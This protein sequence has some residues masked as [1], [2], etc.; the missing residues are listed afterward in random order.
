M[1]KVSTLS[2]LLFVAL[3]CS[4]AASAQRKALHFSGAV[5]NW[6]A[7]YVGVRVSV[8]GPSTT[9]VLGD[10]LFT[11]SND[12]SGGSTM[13]GA[14]VPPT[15]IDK[16]IQMVAVGGDTCVATTALT[17]GSFTGKI[18]FIYRG[19]SEFGHKAL[20]A[21]NAGAVA[22]VIVNNVAGGAV[23]MAA[24]TE[25]GSVTSIPVVMISKEDGDA[26]DQ[27]Y[28]SGVAVTMTI[29]NWGSNKV[30]D[31][32]F[33]PFGTATWHAYA[34][35]FD[36]LGT[37][38]PDA[39]KA[40]DGAFIANYGSANAAGVSLASSLSFTPNSGSASSLHTSTVVLGAFPVADSVVAMFDSS[41]TATNVYSFS[42]S[43]AGRFDQK[44]T[45]NAATDDYLGN[46]TLTNS[47]YATDSLYSKGRYD[48]ANS[49]PYST[50]Y[51]GRKTAADVIWGNM[52]FVNK[53]G[54]AVR[55]V[56]YS[57]SMNSTTAHTLIDVAST[58][59][60]LYK[61]VDANGDKVLQ[62]GELTM[63]GLAEHQY[64]ILSATT[65]DT[66][67]GVFAAT[68]WKAVGP[69]YGAD[70]VT[71]ESNTWYYLAVQVP[72]GYY[73]GCDGVLDQYPRVYGHFYNK[74]N[75]LLE[76]S[77]LNYTGDSTVISGNPADN[78][79]V[80][81]YT[82]TLFIGSVDSFN[83][84]QG[85][86]LIPSVSMIVN[87]NPTP[88]D[89]SH[90]GVNTVNAVIGATVFPN[91]A[92]NTVTVSLSLDRTAPVVSYTIIDGLARFVAKETTTNV[93]NEMHTIN[94]SN[95]PAGNYDLVIT[96]N[97]NSIV[98]KLTI[99]K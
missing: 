54:A 9:P 15:I 98:K 32:G 19:N 33:V 70:Y 34:V 66:S 55:K 25:G 74:P 7:D 36:Q 81:P 39:Y 88:I 13:W 62:N 23:G 86:G 42:A 40:V 83:F 58:M 49:R 22:C 3:L 11:I 84:D 52:Y 29:T 16:P 63:V 95:L 65:G 89:H 67:G 27:Q 71:L 21:Q 91:P 20:Q 61:W 77:N 69:N 45:I 4:T 93:K 30:N 2:K 6:F 31:V 72:P 87:K 51:S 56:Q 46:N 10:K 80:M 64:D 97:G 94:T 48:F 1:K 17:A 12:G 59:V 82:G 24:G 41:A 76:Y 47:F 43:V 68:E 18:A 44:F 57:F 96:A 38:T 5:N 28:R 92:S 78:N 79:P 14:A 85:K 53:G 90:V 50:Q 73:V 75:S 37:G 35:P 60:Y 99:V 8:T 26:I